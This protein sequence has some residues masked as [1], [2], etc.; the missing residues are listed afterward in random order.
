M[1][2]NAATSQLPRD[3]LRGADVSRKEAKPDGPEI[4]GRYGLYPRRGSDRIA[5]ESVT[6]DQVVADNCLDRIDIL[7]IDCQGSEYEI[8]YGTSDGVLALVRKIIVECEFF[9][10]RPEW[11]VER[12]SRFLSRKGFSVHVSERIIHAERLGP[13]AA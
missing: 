5:I 6:P 4:S 12:L 8:L 1:L 10:D 3:E 13:V 2:Q 11:S 7:K 9:P